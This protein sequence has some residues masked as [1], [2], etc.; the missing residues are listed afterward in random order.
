M[1]KG[2]YLR[3][4]SIKLMLSRLSILIE[5]LVSNEILPAAIRG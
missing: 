5:L 4:E 1:R 3:V 2:T